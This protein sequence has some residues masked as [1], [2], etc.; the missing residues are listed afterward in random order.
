MASTTPKQT[1][2]RRPDYI[3]VEPSAL[4]DLKSPLR[5][6]A[7]LKYTCFDISSRYIAVGSN[8]GS[9]YIFDKISLRHL[10]VVFTEVEPSSVNNVKLCSNNK[11]V[12]F[13]LLNGHVQVMELNIDKRQKPDRLRSVNNHMHQIVS[14][15]QWS[16][17]GQKLYTADNAG[18]VVVSIIPTS[19]MKNLV[20]APIEVILTLSVP[21]IQL[22]LH[23][24]KLLVSTRTECFFCNTAKQNYLQIGTKPRDGLFGGCFL[25]G[26]STSPIIYCARPGS[27][28]WE[29]DMEGNVQHTHQFKQLL[30]IPPVRVLSVSR[31]VSW[32]SEDKEFSPLGINFPV[33]KSLNEKFIL[34]WN[35]KKLFILDPLQDQPKVTLWTEFQTEISEACV[36]GSELYIFFVSGEMR[37][38]ILLS[39]SQAVSLLVSRKL[40]TLATQVCGTF[41]QSIIANH[42]HKQLSRSTLKDL[43]HNIQNGCLSEYEGKIVEVFEKFSA[44]VAS[45]SE[46][47]G[48]E[49]SRSRSSSGASIIRLDSG[50]YQIKNSK[51]SASLDSWNET[52]SQDELDSG[53]SS[54]AKL[55]SAATE[56]VVSV[57]DEVESEI[58]FNSNVRLKPNQDGAIRNNES[59]EDQGLKNGD[60]VLNGVLN[61]DDSSLSKSVDL[62]P[63]SM[64]LDSGEHCTSDKEK[65]NHLIHSDDIFADD[66]ILVPRGPSKL[67]KKKLESRHHSNAD[68]SQNNSTPT[69]DIV[70]NAEVSKGQIKEE[71]DV[72][73]VQDQDITPLIVA[74][75]DS[76]GH[77][78][79]STRKK[80]VNVNID[81]DKKSKSGKP[82]RRQS[83]SKLKE[84]DSGLTSPISS[85]AS[86]DV[87][88]I[89]SPGEQSD[90]IPVAQSKSSTLQ[91]TESC[92][93][94][95]EGT[96]LLRSSST[97]ELQSPS[98]SPL[99][100]SWEEPQEGSRRTL[101]SVK[102]SLQSKLANT[103]MM[104]LKTIKEKKMIS[105]SPKNT[106]LPSSVPQVT[107]NIPEEQESQ[108][109]IPIPEPESSIVDLSEFIQKTVK[110]RSAL[111]DLAIVLNPD[112]LC[113]T[114]SDWLTELNIIMKKLNTSKYLKILQSK[115]SKRCRRQQQVVSNGEPECDTSELDV[116][117][118]DNQNKKDRD[119][120]STETEQSD[121]TLMMDDKV[122]FS[123]GEFCN[124]EDPCT[125][126][127]E[128]L[129]TIKDLATKCFN[130]KCFHNIVANVQPDVGAVLSSDICPLCFQNAETGV[131]DGTSVC[132]S[133]TLSEENKGTKFDN[134][135]SETE[136]GITFT[137]TISNVSKSDL[138]N[139]HRGKSVSNTEQSNA[140]KNHIDAPPLES[141]DRC[142]DELCTVITG[143]DNDL[144][145]FVRSY[146]FLLDNNDLMQ[147]VYSRESTLSEDEK[148]QVWKA[149]IQSLQVKYKD[150]NVLLSL[151]QKSRKEC[152]SLLE[153][154]KH[155][156]QRTLLYVY[157]L[158]K[159]FPSEV[160]EFCTTCDTIQPMDIVN[161]CHHYHQ[162]EA[163]F[164]DQF[165]CGKYRELLSSER[166][167]ESN[168]IVEERIVY[169]WL[170]TLLEKT[171]GCKQLKDEYDN[172]WLFSHK[173]SWKD[174]EKI[175]YI[176]QNATAE[177]GKYCLEICRKAG[178]WNGCLLMMKKH[179]QW[180]EMVTLILSVGDLQLIHEMELLPET[181]EQWR[182]FMELFQSYYNMHHKLHH[183]FVHQNR[184][185]TLAAS[186]NNQLATSVTN[187]SNQLATS[188][189]NP[190]LESNEAQGGNHSVPEQVL[191]E[192]LDS[193]GMCDQTCVTSISVDSKVLVQNGQKSSDIN[194]VS[195]NVSCD[196]QC[197]SWSDIASLML[198]YMDVSVCVMMLCEM[199]IPE[200]GMDGSL[201]QSSI[202]MA[203][204]HRQQKN[205]MHNLLEKVDSYLWAKKPNTLMPELQFAIS[206]ERKSK[207]FSKERTTDQLMALLS[208]KPVA[209]RRYNEDSECH[210]GISTNTLKCCRVCNVTLTESV[211]HV[212]PGLLVFECGHG[213]HKYCCQG[214]VC[215]LCS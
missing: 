145:T 146:F 154:T 65:I 18:N 68:S 208:E 4:D 124:V 26:A 60:V 188:A 3:L 117:V 199:D 148:L 122:E 186:P 190:S 170:Q 129:V 24:D 97:P 1:L 54:P 57:L 62:L 165:M 189:A 207:G 191:N 39:A 25:Q 70:I 41:S 28:L 193:Q 175:N 35:K 109:D 19:K 43:M 112:V 13:S 203:L 91:R 110:T 215:L 17:G 14:C 48:S 138:E 93:P 162:K 21:V 87:I 161:L 45:S 102:D 197:I 151:D 119:D 123:G 56:I 85:N 135:L 149:W 158:F 107:P 163:G 118:V 173:V 81:G 181:V 99:S 44:E 74:K 209:G 141:F 89:S 140:E 164:L 172:P 144:S 153:L 185:T 34:T 84:S 15:I 150:D 212:E 131:S 198:Q 214:R 71:F 156:H 168:L 6:S 16:A 7:R 61:S 33:L 174:E 120:V 159:N 27:R 98:Q 36:H 75:S 53:I 72:V 95:L 30:A 86:S 58:D 66:E 52:G 40:W 104:I 22:D 142:H 205:V 94:V 69:V 184:P 192:I 10:Q 121:P 106:E 143:T 37:K 206:V 23:Q 80:A 147:H 47:D 83:R 38:T 103:K 31:D 201:Y 92:P 115:H 176:L 116:N 49:F 32:M 202:T 166:L 194:E 126:S 73:P 59:K 132:R 11:T 9:V 195:C 127:R 155:D 171:E 204:K 88:S 160:V 63:V 100:Q 187:P 101:T 137:V 42:N 2:E 180:K 78:K 12:A 128:M 157:I 179:H 111:Q 20:L 152:I 55:P 105:S 29:V 183:S 125:F 130:S 213:F 177:Q 211:S 90:N 169:I 50:I 178:Y 133:T 134:Q 67:P 114:L 96:G 113:Q 64:Q 79:V 108:Q 200:G 82:R 210:W 76:E 139:P 167:P 136:K 46:T 77:H 5:G 51:S 8:T 196:G 182:S